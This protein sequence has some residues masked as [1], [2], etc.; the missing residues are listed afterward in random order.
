MVET[1]RHIASL[2][3]LFAER[4]HATIKETQLEAKAVLKW[5]KSA[6]A[7][8][9]P[10]ANEQ[11]QRRILVALAGIERLLQGVDEH[12]PS[13]LFRKIGSDWE[14]PI[15]A[16]RKPFR[17]AHQEFFQELVVLS[18]EASADGQIKATSS[19]SQPKQRHR[20]RDPKN[21]A[22]D[23]LVEPHID[24]TPTEI[25]KLIDRPLKEVEKSKRRIKAR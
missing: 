23:D 10:V 18:D 9:A 5:A 6:R 19:E 25:A 3:Q 20:T 15:D 13:E 2:L 16:I 17:D 7:K 14:P 12:D 1:L 8:A 11:L 22:I 4:K 24:K 21:E